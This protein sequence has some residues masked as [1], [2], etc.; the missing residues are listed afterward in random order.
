MVGRDR[1]GKEVIKAKKWLKG[2]VGLNQCRGKR[3]TSG[4][5][6]REAWVAMEETT[7]E[8]EQSLKEVKGKQN[9]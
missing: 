3:G 5:W 4:S 9:Y 6:K 2:L 1:G 7:E 8:R